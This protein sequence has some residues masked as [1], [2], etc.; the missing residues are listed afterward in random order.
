MATKILGPFTPDPSSNEP[1]TIDCPFSGQGTNNWKALVRNI[2]PYALVVIGGASQTWLAP[3][4]QDYYEFPGAVSSFL[5]TPQSLTASGGENGG[6]A[7]TILITAF[8]Q[9]SSYDGVY[10]SQIS[11]PQLEQTFTSIASGTL[12]DSDP[13]ATGP[14]PQEFDA[15]L[16][17]ATVT[18]G[19]PEFGSPCF[20]QLLVKNSAGAFE[21]AKGRFT[22]GRMNFACAGGGDTWE[23]NM[24]GIPQNL[25]S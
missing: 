17:V 2:S 22:P 11:Q 10:P 3:Y 16:V 5:L 18:S 25:P 9:S 6:P 21:D 7:G 1:L 23:L 4:E 15:V 12:T 24:V 20:V 8:D 13:T 19:T 14:L